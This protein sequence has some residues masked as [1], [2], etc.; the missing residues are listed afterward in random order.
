MCS[1]LTTECLSEAHL[2]DIYFLLLHVHEDVL[3]QQNRT[4][5]PSLFFVTFLTLPW[6][7]AWLLGCNLQSV[8]LLEQLSQCIDGGLTG[9]CA[10]LSGPGKFKSE[11]PGCFAE[12]KLPDDVRWRLPLLLLQSFFSSCCRGEIIIRILASNFFPCFQREPPA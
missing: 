3:D 2:F 11:V 4:V 8:I 9:P 5:L 6:N 12:E 7:L 10:H 1:T